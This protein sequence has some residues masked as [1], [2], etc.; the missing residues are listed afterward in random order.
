MLAGLEGT[1]LTDRN[2]V[3]AVPSNSWN[4]TGHT[5]HVNFE[6]Q[7]NIE[8]L[9]GQISAR[10]W[11]TRGSVLLRD[12]LQ[13]GLGKLIASGSRLWNLSVCASW[14]TELALRCCLLWNTGTHTALNPLA[15][16]G[17][18]SRLYITV[19]GKREEL[20]AFVH[21]ELCWYWKQL[22]RTESCW[23]LGPCQSSGILNI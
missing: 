1:L 11:L 5:I 10:D 8:W 4:L 17:C 2:L 3:V 20:W 15:P 9:H 7:K 12:L 16:T 22:W 18:A 14:G 6:K 23:V 21:G 13:R 19:L